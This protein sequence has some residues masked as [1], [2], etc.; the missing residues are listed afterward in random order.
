MIRAKSITIKEFRGIRDLTIDFKGKNYAV[1]GPNGTG[2]SGIVDALEFALTGDISRLSGRG[3][4]S[5]SLKE[6]APHVDSRDYP[7]R[8][9]VILTVF[10]PH[11]NK[12]VKIERNVLYANTPTITPNDPQILEVL[13]QVARHPEF[14]LSR[15]ELIN[16]ILSA[17]AERAKQIQALLRLDRVETFRITLQK[18]ANA[19]QREIAPLKRL[20]TQ[21]QE[22]LLTALEIASLDKDK[23]LE[24]VNKRRKIL[25]L[26][27]IIELSATTSLRD[28]L[29]TPPIGRI[30]Q[31]PKTQSLAD[32]K[33][34]KEI[35]TR[36]TST[37]NIAVITTIAE[38]ME[39]LSAN[40]IIV[41]SISREQFLRSAIDLIE[42]EMC[43]VCDTRWDI[44]KLKQIIT[45][46]LRQFE[47]AGRMRSEIEKQ[48][49]PFSTILS[50]LDASL[51]IV[52]RYGLMLAPMV[53]I[54]VVRVFKTALTLRQKQ[55]ETFIP[56]PPAIAAVRALPFIPDD[57]MEVIQIIEKTI[58]AIPE[59]TEQDAA[60]TYLTIAQER[61][62]N[63][64]RVSLQLKKTEDQAIL[65]KNIYE[66][67]A[68]TSTS[69]LEGI[70]KEV[71][72]N[73]VE[74]YRY[75]NRKDEGDF[76]A[77]LVMPV[78]GRLDFKV[79]FFG[80]GFFPPGAYHSEGHQDGMGICLYLA[81]MRH[82][83]GK[84]FTFAVL[85]DVLMSVDSDHRRE[86]CS[87]LIKFF[88]DTQFIFTTH[89]EIWLRHM[90]AVGLISSDASS[91]HFRTWYVNHGPI[92]WDN[93]DIW[94]QIK[95]GV[96]N[97]DIHSAAGL[98]R[99][100]LE[101][102]SAEICHHLGAPVPFRGDARYE[103]GDLLP[104]AILRF[105][106][107]LKKG[108]LSAESWGKTKEVEE[109]TKREKAFAELV[110]KS[111]VEQWQI[112]SAIHFNEWENL[113]PADFIPVVEIFKGLVGAFI[114]PNT[115]CGSVLYILPERKKDPEELRCF[116]GATTINLL[117]KRG[118]GSP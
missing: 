83:L 7:D 17:P 33:K 99:H 114:C 104:Q 105:K 18:V 101:H 24:A 110:A 74:L 117:Q 64:R 34:L 82:L 71:E 68:N 9:T 84:S 91:I 16:Y 96:E 88:P 14:V 75:I 77:E 92:Q 94:Q 1:C 85:D 58:E 30:S 66:I 49:E 113:Q 23:L 38:R 8:A 54:A 28:G 3:T 29:D 51:S 108:R 102:I 112:N 43:P 56:L 50:E 109:I 27:P 48:L 76:T 15:R 32:I 86:V 80:R 67:Y 4:G 19:K 115:D 97:N 47:D 46:K 78:S 95:E 35:I 6:H 41:N 65:L 103:L 98:L 62:E 31:V 5:V 53:D 40:P 22:Q 44:D 10:I 72:K 42:N 12:E 107:L 36:I 79:D 37:E 106:F 73:F 118:V 21:V 63:Y 45:T 52:C 59:A 93:Y 90:R 13:Q 39:I 81:L 70:Y 11:L 111:N 116:C 20:K 100:Y 57:V 25:T 89:D 60:R 55:I 2:K 87:L 26:P 61:L 69:V